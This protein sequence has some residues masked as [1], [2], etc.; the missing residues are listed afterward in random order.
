[1]NWEN[2]FTNWIWTCSLTTSGLCLLHVFECPV[3]SD[4]P[5][6]LSPPIIWGIRGFL[7]GLSLSFPFLPDADGQ[8]GKKGKTVLTDSL[9]QKKLHP[10]VLQTLP[11]FNF[12]FIYSTNPNF[13]VVSTASFKYSTGLLDIFRWFCPGYSCI[14]TWIIRYVWVSHFISHHITLLRSLM[15][16]FLFFTLANLLTHTMILQ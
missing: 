11:L 16:L 4:V 12:L 9:S 2:P 10:T 8:G 5:Q 14:M 15:C 13:P 6:E 3:C 1:M 7:H